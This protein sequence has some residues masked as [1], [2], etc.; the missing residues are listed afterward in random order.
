VGAKQITKITYLPDL[1]A[2]PARVNRR[3]GEMQISIK[4]WKQLPPEHRFFIMLHEM[5][6]VI[7]QS[8]NEEEVDNWAFNQYA[9]AGYSLKESV[10]ALTRVLNMDNPAHNWRAYL[11]LQR[12]REFDY[13][14]YG[15]KNAF[16]NEVCRC[17]SPLCTKEHE[18]FTFKN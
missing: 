11:Q 10:F 8:R 6:H 7:L 12:A 14:H 17:N 9:K 15:N 13:F 2:T 1:G 4:F 5:G 3:T 18:K 16:D